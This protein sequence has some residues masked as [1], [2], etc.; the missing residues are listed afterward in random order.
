MAT[1]FS[2]SEEDVEI[3]EG[4][5]YP[6]AYANLCR[7]PHLFNAY[8]QGPPFAYTPYIL[9]SQEASRASELDQF[10]PV[11]D[12]DR[13]PSANPR[14]YVSLLWKQ[15]NHLGNAG[16]DPAKFRVDMYGN[17][18]FFNA[19][20]GSPLAWEIDH[21]F[22]CSRGGKTVPSNLKLVQWQVCKRKQNNLE[23]LIPW[24]DLQLGVSVNQFL[25]IFASTNSDFRNRAFQWLFSEGENEELNDS[26]AVESLIFPPHFIVSEQQV[27]LAPAAIVLLRRDIDASALQSLDLNQPL[28]SNSP[29]TG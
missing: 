22:P 8:N 23:F 4:L 11:I 12:A 26:Q 1:T 25:S 2:F 20:P 28:R 6:K 13:K 19:D 9:H 16:F 15:L 24:W 7:N 14:N 18:L 3:D 21:W 27:G 29:M 5:G 17:V 10:F